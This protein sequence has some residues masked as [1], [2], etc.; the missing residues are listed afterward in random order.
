MSEDPEPSLPETGP[1]YVVGGRRPSPMTWLL[2]AVVAYFAISLTLSWLRAIELLTGTWD[3]GL[4]QQALW[5]TGHGRAFYEAADAETGGYHSLL[6][7]HTVFVLYLVA[8][9]YAALPFEAT[10]LVLQSM[11]VAIAAV[12]LYF[13]GRDLSGSSRLALLT[14]VAYLVWTPT[15]SSNLYDFHPEAFLPLEVFT[16]VLLWERE[17]FAAG[18]VAV[19][20][21]FATFELAPVLIFFVAVFF[22]MPS[23]EAWQRGR[24]MAVTRVPWTSRV[25]GL[26]A[27][28]GSPRVTASLVLLAASVAAYFLLLYLRVDVLAASLGTSPVPIA[29]SGYVIGGTPASL[30][31]ALSNPG[32][33]F[34]A[35]VTYWVLITALLGFVPLLAP[36]A[37][38]L[39][40]PWFG[41]TL[42]SS[43]LSYVQ[44]GFQYGFVAGASLLVAFAYG[45]PRA[46]ELLEARSR[47]VDHGSGI[48]LPREVRRH[49]PTWTGHPWGIVVAGFV[50]L[51]G[52][53]LALSPANPL[54]QD[55]GLGSGYQISYTPSSTSDN[56]GRLAGLI[57]SGATV[58]ASDNLFPIV[59]N[60]ENAYSFYWGPNRFLSL[61]FNA[62]HLPTYVL[63]SADQTAA[64]PVWL[65]LDLYQSVDFGVR[66]VD[67]SSPV[68]PVLLFE[69]A[70]R[71]GTNVFGTPP[72]VPLVV[73][74]SSMVDLT[75]GYVL[76]VPGAPSPDAAASAPGTLGTFFEGPGASL[77]PG[78]YSVTLLV[79]ASGTPGA[80][81]PTPGEPTLSIDG[82][83]Y[84][85]PS[86]FTKTFDF[87]NLSGPRWTAVTFDLSFSEPAIQFAVQG[88]VL[89]TNV[90]VLLDQL[91]IVPT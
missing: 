8:P 10:L 13:L 63:I 77:P 83:A 49:H 26:R 90:Q 51:A 3:M 37:L 41:F 50:V 69:N 15:L 16:I 64:V 35:K 88:I 86:T 55:Q 43:N 38:V 33:G 87:D 57:P 30:G 70:Y 25:R 28:L 71:G 27:V 32:I 59:A 62:T 29:S 14:A 40:L 68:G 19:A 36:R 42:L 31:L 79:S 9:L 24:S 67:W 66:G 23:R 91:E 21:A 78:T 65:A 53:N 45:L 72:V 60:D 22:L 89:G 47:S 39:G 4:Y 75:S 7:V 2:V 84:A 56:I 81:V 80:S 52:V 1:A 17:R 34:E 20:A 73:A 18:A 5:S 6:Q 48:G 54:M 61:P 82:A 46:V 85:Q 11:V 58:V 76:A 12:P 74:G 44:L